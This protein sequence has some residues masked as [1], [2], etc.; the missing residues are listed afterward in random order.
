M[1]H[2]IAISSPWITVKVSKCLLSGSVALFLTILRIRLPL[3]KFKFL[4]DSIKCQGFIRREAAV[5]S[6]SN[7]NLKKKIEFHE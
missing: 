4:N 1:C 6:S 2:T 3:R 5:K 7:H